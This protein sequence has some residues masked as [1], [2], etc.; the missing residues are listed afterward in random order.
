LQNTD[1]LAH[2]LSPVDAQKLKSIQLQGGGGFFPWTPAGAPLAMCPL[3]T[4]CPPAVKTWRRCYVLP[5]ITVIQHH[6]LC[7]DDRAVTKAALQCQPVT[8]VISLQ[9]WYTK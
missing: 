4:I 7:I 6:M 9:L 3:P 2:L 8:T 5:L 1:K